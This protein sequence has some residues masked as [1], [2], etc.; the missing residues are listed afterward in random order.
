MT[1]NTIYPHTKQ[2]T[3]TTITITTLY[4]KHNIK[5]ITINN[6]TTSHKTKHF[7]LNIQKQFPKIT[8]QKIIINKTNTSIYSTSKLTTQKFPNLNISLHNTISITHHLQNPLTKLIKINP[9]SINI[10]QYQHNINQTQ[11]THKLNTI[12]KNYINTINI[13]LN[14][15]S[16]PLLTHITNLTHIITQNIITWHNKNNQFQNHQQLLKI[17]HLKPKTFKQYTNFLHINHNNN[18]LNTSTIH[19]KTYPIIKH[20]LTTTQQTLKNLINNNN[21]LHNLKTSNFTN[22]KF[23]IPTITNIIKKLKKPNHNPHPKFKT[24]Q[25]TN[26]IKTINNLQPNIILKNTITNITNFNTFININIHQNNLIHI[27]SLSNKFIKNP[28]TIIKTNNIIKIKILKINLQHKHITL[29]IHLNKQPD[30]TNT[31]HNNN[32]KHPQNNHPTTKPHNH[33]TQPT[34][35]NTIIN[36]LTTTIN[37]KH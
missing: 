16:I 22:K 27:S 2:T 25:F 1:T 35:N 5:L 14:T 37:K 31:H 6:N 11:L 18:P 23:N 29:T 7:Y 36:T 3:K 21:K 9:K 12:I 15:T 30:K 34:N 8:T 26:N 20:I 17:N 33:K 28:H 10:N 19:P 32:N 4:K 13:N 24:T